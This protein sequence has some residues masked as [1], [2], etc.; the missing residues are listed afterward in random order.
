VS[1]ARTTPRHCR[2][3]LL[4]S[5]SEDNCRGVSNP[6]ARMA[7]PRAKSDRLR[8]RSASWAS[9]L[10]SC[11]RAEVV[12]ARRRQGLRGHLGPFQARTDHAHHRN[13]DR[14]PGHRRA[15]SDLADRVCA[16]IFNGG[17]FEPEALCLRR[18]PRGR[19][20]T[21]WD[22]LLEGGYDRH[23]DRVPARMAT[24]P[25]TEP[26]QLRGPGGSWELRAVRLQTGEQASDIPF[27]G[28][29]PNGLRPADAHRPL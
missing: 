18:F 22:Y 8:R 5:A 14:P 11:R 20:R 28:G 2:A 16:D 23:P 3:R 24:T 29:W 13:P 10:P 4:R 6:C 27:A 26:V 12:P 17:T 15:N 21:A 19:R 9:S 25:V 7:I 1:P